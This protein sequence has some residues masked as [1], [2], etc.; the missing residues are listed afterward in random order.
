MKFMKRGILKRTI[1][2]EKVKS[3]L[4]ARIESRQVQFDIPFTIF[5]HLYLPAKTHVHSI[6]IFRLEKNNSRSTSKA[7]VNEYDAIAKIFLIFYRL[8]KDKPPEVFKEVYIPANIQRNNIS[9]KNEFY[10][11]CY[12]LPPGDYLLSMAITSQNLEKIGTQYFDFS[13]PDLNTNILDTTPIIFVKKIDRLPKPE[14]EA[15]VHRG[16]F[17]YSVLQIEPNLNNIFAPVDNLDAFYFIVG[18]QVDEK[19]QF[20]IEVKYNVYKDEEKVISY[21]SA[22]YNYPLISQPLPL[23]KKHNLSPGIYSLSLE[24]Y[25]NLSGKSKVKRKSFE[26]K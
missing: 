12:P 18:A 23:L 16:F 6:F 7:S 19:G 5:K 8:M 25:D 26:I 17:T 13:L 3:V 1:I 4:Q 14:K 9:N 20:A 24:I 11:I 15:L 10:T 2:P 22:K 21:E